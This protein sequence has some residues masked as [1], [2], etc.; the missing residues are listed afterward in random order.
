MNTTLSTKSKELATK[1]ITEELDLNTLDLQ[2][3]EQRRLFLY[4]I[5]KR[6]HLLSKIKPTN[7]KSFLR[8]AID[9]DYKYFLYLDPKQYTDELI[10]QFLTKRLAEEK[11]SERLQKDS[12]FKICQSIDNKIVFQYSYATENGSELFFFDPELNVPLSLKSSFKLTLKLTNAL[13]LINKLDLHASQI[14]K[15]TLQSTITDLID[16]QYKAFLNSFIKEKKIGY[17]T[18][19]TV[20]KDFETSARALF[21]ET[22]LPY[23]ISA[24]DFVIKSI[25]I[26]KELQ[27][28]IEDQAFRI[29]RQRADSE[30]DSEFAKKALENY[31]A[32]LALQEKYPNAEHS[33]TEYEKDLALKRY[34][35]KTGNFRE[36]SVDHSV[37]L[38]SAFD[39]SDATIETEKDL[40]PT[41]APKPNVFRKAFILISLLLLF[42][43]V[44]IMLTASAGA[45]CI[46]LGVSFAIMGSIAAFNYRKFKTRKTEIDEGVLET[47][48]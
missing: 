13:T 43:S 18:L 6:P 4:V 47:N 23:G 7:A 16:N 30:A 22:L 29:R 31:E 44:V 24:S 1:Y 46:I 38:A 20:L 36:E 40:V 41:I 15:N 8:F 37:H 3:A 42:F 35:I 28:K 2:S 32:K 12:R 45:G 33:L 9:E 27:Y 17:Y 39:A 19:C 5:E 26:P 25:A 34:L 21:E 14:G 10:Q 11:G 48:E